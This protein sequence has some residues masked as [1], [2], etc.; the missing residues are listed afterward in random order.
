MCLIVKRYDFADDGD[1]SVAELFECPWRAEM[2]DRVLVILY[3]HLKS[4]NLIYIIHKAITVAETTKKHAKTTGRLNSTLRTF[5][6]S[7]WVCSV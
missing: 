3:L 5:E 2:V 4:A 6:D 1:V 7:R